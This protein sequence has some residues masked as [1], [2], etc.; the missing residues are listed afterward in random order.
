MNPPALRATDVTIRYGRKVAVDHV[1]LDIPGGSVYALL[2]RNGAGKS[3][4]VR[5]I[6]GQLRPDSGHVQLF[7]ADAWNERAKLMDRVGVVSEDAD[8]P[9]EMRVRDLGGFSASLYSRWRQDAFD[10]RLDRFGISQKTRFGELSKGQKKQVSLALALASSPE[11]VILD[12]PTLGLDVV[13]RKSLFEE[14]I[15]DMADRGI[16]VLITTHDLASIEA[17]ADRVGMLKKGQL[18][19]DEEVETLKARF[20]RIRFTSQPTALS[21]V[22]LVAAQVRQWGNATEAVVTNYDDLAIARF[23][24]EAKV[25]TEVTSMSLEDIFIAVAGEEGAQS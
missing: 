3:S 24:D 1:S 12:D 18:V 4:L 9:A 8:A 10:T 19:L 13:A 14:V 22:N 21:S 25:T 6:L 2:G 11:L 20:R 5:A 23:Q 16:T 7:G 17:I 15:T